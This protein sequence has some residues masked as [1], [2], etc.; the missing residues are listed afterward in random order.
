MPSDR[1]AK[2]KYEAFKRSDSDW[3]VC[4]TIDGQEELAIA[5]FEGVTSEA[6]ARAFAALKNAEPMKIYV[7]D[8]VRI[9]EAIREKLDSLLDDS[10]CFTHRSVAY[11][12]SLAKECQPLARFVADLIPTERTAGTAPKQWQH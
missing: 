10:K 8:A 4:R 6:D 12:Q 3:Y 7:A 1:E 5:T 2:M 11:P 9:V